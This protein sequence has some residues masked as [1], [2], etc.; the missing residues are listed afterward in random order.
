MRPVHFEVHSDLV[1]CI[2]QFYSAAQ[3]GRRPP[4]ICMLHMH[5]PVLFFVE[6]FFLT[7]ATR[8]TATAC[9]GG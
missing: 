4:S 5:L 8:T 2:Q 3:T 1:S 9:E 6:L 7:A